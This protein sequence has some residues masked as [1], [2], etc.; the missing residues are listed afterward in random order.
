M[1][2][3]ERWGENVLFPA[4]GPANRHAIDGGTLAQTEMQSPV[5]LRAKTAAPRYLL[6]LLLPIPEDPHLGADGAAVTGLSF[7]FELYP[8]IARRNGIPVKHQG[9]VLIG[10]Y[11]IQHAPIPEIGQ[12]DGAPIVNIR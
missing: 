11:G 7:Q 12:R 4:G 6:Q 2:S 3:I 8:V 1:Q 5:I 9:S 10:Y